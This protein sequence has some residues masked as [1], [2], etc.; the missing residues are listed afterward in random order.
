MQQ[1]GSGNSAA[2]TKVGFKLHLRTKQQKLHPFLTYCCHPF[3]FVCLFLF[4]SDSLC[5]YFSVSPHLCCSLLSPTCFLVYSL[6]RLSVIS[7]ISATPTQL[8]YSSITPQHWVSLQV[9]VCACVRDNEFDKD[10]ELLCV[11]FICFM[12]LCM[13]TLRGE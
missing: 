6:A 9:C 10:S 11:C 7:S 13:F 4:I 3:F 5:L 1:N 12:G 2:V 8:L